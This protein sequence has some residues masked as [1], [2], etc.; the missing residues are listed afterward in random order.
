MDSTS[1]ERPGPARRP[2]S[3]QEALDHAR[4]IV[5]TVRTPLLILDGDLRVLTANRYFYQTFARRGSTTTWS[6]R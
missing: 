6:S 4:S 2:Q 3:L 1:R 5:A